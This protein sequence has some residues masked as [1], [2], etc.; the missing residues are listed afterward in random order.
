MSEEPRDDERAE[1]D[2]VD[3]P[4]WRSRLEAVGELT[5]EIVEQI[6][7][8]H[9]DRGS[10]AIDA[11]GEGRVKGYKDFTVVVGNSDEY[12]IEEGACTCKD[13]TYNLDPEDPTALCWHA[14][15]AEIAKS[16]GAVEHHDMYYSE[17]RDFI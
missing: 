2:P 3:G 16:V 12:V 13:A 5:P 14:L 1:D 6:L 17:V 8:V 9:G 11:V 10:R 15:A 7:A 4:Q